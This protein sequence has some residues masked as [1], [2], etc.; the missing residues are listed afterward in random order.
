MDTLTTE[1]REEEPQDLW[2]LLFADDLVYSA[3]T[4]Q[5]IPSLEREN[6]TRWITEEGIDQAVRQ[7]VKEVWRKWKEVTGIVLD[8]KIQL[9]LKMKVH[10]TVFRPVLLYGAETWALRRK[11]E[12]LLQRM[13]MRMYECDCHEYMVV[14]VC[15]HFNDFYIFGL[16]RSPN[17]DDS[18]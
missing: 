11:E 15:S 5:K 4:K 3:E 17:F 6:G 16:Y 9:K 18:I 1:L 13:E 8:K 10:K 7:R 12:N 14:R 2:E